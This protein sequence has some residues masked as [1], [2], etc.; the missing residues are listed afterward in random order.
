MVEFKEEQKQIMIEN[1]RQARENER[2]KRE[3]QTMMNNERVRSAAQA[4]DVGEAEMQRKSSM[5][6]MRIKFGRYY[7]RR[8]ESIYQEGQVYCLWVRDVE[9]ESLA[10]IEYKNFLKV[11]NEP[12]EEECREVKR[13]ELEEREAKIRENRQTAEAEA[14]AREREKIMKQI[15]RAEMESE[16]MEARYENREDEGSASNSAA[17][18][19]GS[20]AKENDNMT[21][22]EKGSK[23]KADNLTTEAKGGK[24]REANFTAETRNDETEAEE[25][26][27][28]SEAET[29]EGTIEITTKKTT[30]IT[31]Q[32]EDFHFNW[33]GDTTERDQDDCK[34][35]NRSRDSDKY[36][37][38]RDRRSMGELPRMHQFVKATLQR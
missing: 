22:E 7:G 3:Q 10:V 34:S 11:R 27:D 35:D 1:E 20:K 29:R 24:V 2:K 23:A 21:A 33:E 4:H 37:R 38:T 31:E 14:E 32:E 16:K 19:K 6:E 36:D 18:T 12:W 17:E 9:T 28:R 15:R 8:C 30:M 13:I 25:T 5:K 26:R